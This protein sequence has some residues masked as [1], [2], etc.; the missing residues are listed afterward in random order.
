L[1]AEG[2]SGPTLNLSKLSTGWEI[3]MPFNSLDKRMRSNLVIAQTIISILFGGFTS[4]S[5]PFEEG[6]RKKR[7]EQL[8]LIRE[9]DAELDGLARDN[10]P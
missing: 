3:T 7:I 6:L 2:S 4:A 10:S 5:T 9:M 1:T 8:R